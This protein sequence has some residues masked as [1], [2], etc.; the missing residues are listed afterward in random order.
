[1][2]KESQLRARVIRY[3]GPRFFTEGFSRISTEE[4]SRELGI[5]KK[6]LYRE[7]R[8]KEEIVRAVVL[9]QLRAVERELAEVFDDG[10]RG[11]IERLG[12]QL[13]IAT[14]MVGTLGRPFLS[15]LSRYA[16]AV[17]EEIERFRHERVFSRLEKVILRG[18]EEGTVRP[19]IDPRLLVSIIATVA[20][21]LLIPDNFV[22]TEMNPEKVIQHMGMLITRGVLTPEGWSRLEA[23]HAAAGVTGNGHE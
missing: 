18:K 21:N 23:T 8:S 20:N 9:Q 13:R 15:D 19:E 6:T 10:N 5:S 17:W 22:H 2:E 16:P 11:F 4:L 1:M 3:A 7:F 12:A 14:R